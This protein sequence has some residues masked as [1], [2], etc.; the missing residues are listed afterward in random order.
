MS[1]LD[2]GLFATGEMLRDRGMT[3]ANE[4]AATRWKELA[5][6]AIARCAAI[7]EDF[8]TDEVWVE[9][10]ASGRDLIESERNPS[11]LGPAMRRAARANVIV[12]VGTVRPSTRPSQHCNVLRIWKRA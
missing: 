4:S 7:Y 8:T 5:A 11:A 3:A 9:I 1:A 6:E 2:F 10:A 12:K